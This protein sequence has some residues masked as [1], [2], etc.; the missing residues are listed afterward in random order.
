MMLACVLVEAELDEQFVTD[1]QPNTGPVALLVGANEPEVWVSDEVQEEDDGLKTRLLAV[2][3][4]GSEIDGVDNR[5]EAEPDEQF[6]T[7]G[8][9]NT[10]PV[11][12]LVGAK[13]NDG[14]HNVEPEAWVSDEVLKEDDGLKTRLVV[15]VENGSEIDGVDNWLKA[16]LDEQFVTDGHP[17]TGPVALLMGANEPEA[18]V[19]D[20][21]QEKGDG[22][23][24]QLLLLVADGSETDGVDN[25]LVMVV[26]VVMMGGG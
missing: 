8:Q 9:P 12:L 26:L 7:D 4:N 14:G 15:V 17:N 2:V 22:L 11:A 6:V 5:L 21:V 18:C 16:E 23:K 20:E 13:P 24:T 1:G 19:S 3:E 25:R 10:G